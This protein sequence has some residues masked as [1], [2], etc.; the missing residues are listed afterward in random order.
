MTL[1]PLALAACGRTSLTGTPTPGVDS[2]PPADA[3]TCSTDAECDDGLV[4]NGSE[5]CQAGACVPGAPPVCDDGVDC[6]VDSCSEIGGGC[7]I[8]PDNSL[9]PEGELCRADGCTGLECRTDADCQDDVFCNGLEACVDGMCVPGMVPACDD[10]VPCTSN[11]CDPA[12]D[13]CENPPADDDRDGFAPV[14]CG[15]TDCDDMNP[16]VRPDADEDCTDLQDNDCDGQLD[17]ADAECVR[18]PICRCAPS[19]TV[20][21]DGRDDDCDG[22][23]DCA[24]FDCAGNPACC[25]AFEICGN[26]LDDDCDGFADCN[27][28]G[29]RMDPICMCGPV[30]VC[31]NGI[32]DDCN[33][34]IDCA[35]MGCAGRPECR[36]GPVEI[37][38][39]GLDDD[40]NGFSDCADAACAMLPECMCLPFEICGNSRD[41]DC[42]M[43][44]D[45]ADP[46][47]AMDPSC[48]CGPVEI[49]GNGRDDDCNGFVDCADATCSARPECMCGPIEF[50]T[51]GVDDDCDMLTDC[52]DPDCAGDP[53]C[54]T[55]CSTA[56]DLGSVVGAPVAT[57]TTVG[58]PNTLIPSC[59]GGSTAGERVFRWRAPTSGRFTFDT[60]GSTYD[61][62]LYVQTVCGGMDLACD[63]DSGTGLQSQVILPVRAGQVLFVVVDGFGMSE[64]NFQLNIT[65]GAPTEI[66]DNFRDDDG[67]GLRDCADPDCASDP[68]CCMPT[69]EVCTD[70]A[71]QDCDSLVD[72]ADPD[73]SAS[74]ACCVPS[75]EICDNATDDD[76]DFRIDCGDPDCAG[77]PLCC[78]PVPEV[79]DDM[80]D[81][82]CDGLIDCADPD[83]TGTPTCCVPTGPEICFNGRDDDCDTRV[84]CLDSD[85]IGTPA[86]CVP[87]PEVC[88]DGMDNDCDTAIDCVDPDCAMDPLCSPSCPDR[89]IGS[90]SG[91]VVASGTT[92]GGG[93]DFTP[94]CGPPGSAPDVTL[95]WTAPTT[96][97]FFVATIGSGFDTTLTRLSSCTGPEL[98]CNDDAAMATTASFLTFFATAGERSVFVIDG[99]GTASGSW[100]LV[101]FGM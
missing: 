97:M 1:A 54:V 33:G 78:V 15:G 38:G 4:C 17:C 68:A 89:D 40:C 39:N 60:N 34:L 56:T 35:D 49:C 43:L 81:Q 59:R 12:T 62:T 67:D 2:G 42:N 28:F 63:D 27:D 61:T 18:D 13:R 36:C 11:F 32:D 30:E 99:S 47:C 51:G 90:R 71:D 79:C 84:D 29:C 70:G 94:S 53:A 75:P 16:R 66:C 26:M 9:C 80:I 100:Q 31:G 25:L 14:A 83:C 50:C 48:M 5:S 65:R 41:D 20:C 6:T 3:G 52:A 95:T 73:C 23:L 24:D 74:P 8:F 7:I 101:I 19:E 22:M 72:C 86:C 98:G 96:G 58:A 93:D 37:C 55:S 85:C 46:A 10:G 88:G 44:I 76:C 92:V 21:D 69:P 45:C 77:S 87:T 91:G 57:G 64:G 82:D